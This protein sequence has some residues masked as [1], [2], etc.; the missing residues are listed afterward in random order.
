[1]VIND[2]VCRFIEIKAD[3]DVIRKHQLTRIRQLRAAGFQA[4]II[5]VNWTIVPN[6]TYVVVDVETTGGRPG[7]HRITEI[8]AVKIQNGEIIDEWSSLINPQRS[9]P[10]NITRITNITNEMVMN[11]PVFAEI[12]DSFADFMG[13]AI[14]AAHNVNFDYGFIKAEF[15]MIDRRFRHPKI[16]TCSSMRK[17][18]PGHASYSLKN[19]SREFQIDL[20]SHH[21]ALCDAKAAAQLLFLINAKRLEN[22]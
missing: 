8:G 3:G 2:D 7:L 6:Q 11:A 12:A 14:F 5:K 1:M 10:A 4:D 20:K 13:D 16:C 19:L 17:L 22:E 9:I 21:R 18:Y 15:E